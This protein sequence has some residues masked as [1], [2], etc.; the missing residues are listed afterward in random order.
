MN[1]KHIKPEC[2]ITNQEEKELQVQHLQAIFSF[3][4]NLE[5]GEVF[6]FFFLLFLKVEITL[7]GFADIPFP[8]NW[9]F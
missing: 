4:P 1:L 8:N 5:L 2:Y 7:F 3:H 9:S 6:F